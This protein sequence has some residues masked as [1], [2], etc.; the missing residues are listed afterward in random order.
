[1]KVYIYD[2]SIMLEAETIEENSQCK[3]IEMEAND[4]GHSAGPAFTSDGMRCVSIEI[5]PRPCQN[6]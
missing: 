2:G 6:R 3:E 4:L 5:N 1:M